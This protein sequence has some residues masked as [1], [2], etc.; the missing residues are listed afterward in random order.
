MHSQ[1]RV[2][3]SSQKIISMHSPQVKLLF[4]DI[5]IKSLHHKFLYW[6]DSLC[7]YMVVPLFI[8]EARVVI[9]GHVNLNH[10]TCI[11]YL[12]QL[13]HVLQFVVTNVQCYVCWTGSLLS[14]AAHTGYSGTPIS[15]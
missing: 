14:T 10:A 15:S 1:G 9:I 3:D 4:H 2:I 7:L 8:L 11:C 6:F 13:A 12:L 5:I